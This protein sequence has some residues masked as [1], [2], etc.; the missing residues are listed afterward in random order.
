MQAY[1]DSSN[2]TT[3]VSVAVYLFF[4]ASDNM[5]TALIRMVTTSPGSAHSS[6]RGSRSPV[7]TVA[8]VTHVQ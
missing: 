6:V 4:D 3:F 8:R 7:K 2:T 1:C 5:T